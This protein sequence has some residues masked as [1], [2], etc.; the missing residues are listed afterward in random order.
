MQ[1]VCDAE[2]RELQQTS[3]ANQLAAELE[4]VRGRCDTLE[5]ELREAREAVAA[6]ELREK[7]AEWEARER[8]HAELT[9]VAEIE[10]RLEHE[11]EAMTETVHR[12]EQR[13]EVLGAG[14]AQQ[15]KAILDRER[16]V[17]AR[18][19]AAKDAIA[20]AQIDAKRARQQLDD[21]V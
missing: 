11:R 19:R 1:Q 5:G 14:I 13:V 2:A 20:A 3:R 16:G 18:E 6:A 8:R 15:E 12:L 9:R 4:L 21:A 7:K 17:F 10:W